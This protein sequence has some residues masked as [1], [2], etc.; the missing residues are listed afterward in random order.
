MKNIVITI[1]IALVVLIM[2]LYLIS[3]QVRETESALVTRFG[4]P[5]RTITEPK[6]CFKLPTPIE[7]VHRFDSR[8]HVFEADLGETTTKGAVPIIVNTY[9]VWRISE[10]LRFLNSVG[11]VK[12]AE[13][14]LY[15]QITDTQNRVIG[16]HSFG[17]FVNSDPAKIKFKVIEAEMLADLEQTLSN[18][19]GIEIKTLGIK[20]LKVSKDVTVKVFER[21]KAARSLRTKA[22]ISEG[23][24][25]ATRIRG[26]ANFK[27]SVL[28]TTAEARAL[29]IRGQGDAEAAR[30][31]KLLEEDP[32]LAMFLRNIDS[33]EKMLKERSTIVIPADSEPFK[34]LKEAPSLKPK[35]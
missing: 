15:S 32:E 12:E 19:Y 34:L 10:P 6:L 13:V 18:E 14:K 17:E 29:D 8:M 3:F 24:G 25:Q 35:Q 4:K 7:R 20:Q 5:V 21:M 1:F 9:V 31:Y 16:Q 2:G 26:D 11:T 30:H 22:T 27:K 33:L 28:R 23:E